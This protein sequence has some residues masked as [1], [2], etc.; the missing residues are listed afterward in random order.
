VTTES[1]EFGSGKSA[2]AAAED[3]QGE[4]RY[5]VLSP[6]TIA[7][8]AVLIVAVGVAVAVWM[9]LAYTGG[10]ADANRVQLA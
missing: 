6:R 3:T 5:Q 8:W 7:A 4:V 9:L 1:E 10:N 2:R